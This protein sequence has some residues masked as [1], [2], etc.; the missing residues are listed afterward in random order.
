M[1]LEERH[2]F[3]IVRAPLLEG[4]D[5][6]DGARGRGTV[7]DGNIR[8]NFEFTDPRNFGGCWRFRRMEAASAAAFRA[9]VR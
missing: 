4:I 3:L 5:V 8:R 2:K 9:S 7:P 6:Q 1:R